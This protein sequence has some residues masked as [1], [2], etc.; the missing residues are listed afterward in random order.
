M[1]KLIIK[2]IECLLRTDADLGTEEAEYTSIEYLQSDI[3]SLFPLSRYSVHFDDDTLKSS[4]LPPVPYFV[5]T[6]LDDDSR[7]FHITIEGVDLNL[8]TFKL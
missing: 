8:I 5:V 1:I 3:N 6:D 4:N 7:I 2:G